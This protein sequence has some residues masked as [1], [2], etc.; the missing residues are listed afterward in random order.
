[1]S[2]DFE[3]FF[4]RTYPLMMA[5]AIL[6]GG[7]RADAED[8]VAQAYAN[9][10]RYWDTVD[11]P[12]AY[13]HVSMVRQVH[14]MAKKRYRQGRLAALEVPN[15]PYATPEETFEAKQLLAEISG[16]PP[17]QRAVLVL[18]CLEGV[19]Q[20]KV[21]S[22]LGIRRGTVGAH[23]HQARA[24]LV[25]RL[26]LPPGHRRAGDALVPTTVPHG[27]GLPIDDLVVGLR[28]TERWLVD[29]FEGD[30]NTRSGV[31]ATVDRTAPGLPPGRLYFR[32]GT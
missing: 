1:M 5:R 25:R 21:A 22:M 3:T 19:E 2:E 7:D 13:L 15:P 12:E 4:R 16:L 6:L 29:A 10:H 26:G 14:A 30:D 31:R 17:V 9:V 27:T 18:C 24:N 28:D 20:R 8:A 23:L 32:R 11:T